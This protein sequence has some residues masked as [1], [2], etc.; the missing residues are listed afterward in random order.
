MRSALVAAADRTVELPVEL[1]CPPPDRRQR[2][3]ALYYPDIGMS[4]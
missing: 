3:D 1:A 2:L 4:A